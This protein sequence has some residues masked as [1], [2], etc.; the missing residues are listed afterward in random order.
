VVGRPGG[1]TAAFATAGALVA[2]TVAVG[3]VTGTRSAPMLKVRQVDV[4]AEAPVPGAD[5]STSRAASRQGSGRGV[6][7]SWVAT[8]ATASGRPVAAVR[9]YGAATLRA[10][11]E[12]PG[13]HLGWTTLAGIGWVESLQGTIGDRVLEPDGRPDRPILGVELDGSGEVA[14]VPDASGGYQRALGPMQFIPSTWERWA[15]DG[16]G[17]GVSDPQDVDDAAASAARYL[18]ASGGDLATGAGWSAAVFSYNHSDVYVRAVRDAAEVYA[19]R[20]S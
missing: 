1:R 18:C 11:E 17:D 6:S 20:T 10:A 16:D 4:V 13:C 7:A 2:A 5:P 12:S 15:T 8:T 19:E 9:A 14:A 3:V